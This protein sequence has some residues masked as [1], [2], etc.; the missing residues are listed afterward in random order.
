MQCTCSVK[1]TGKLAG[2]EDGAHGLR[3]ALAGHP[4]QRLGPAPGA[5][6]AAGG[7]D[8]VTLAAGASTI[9]KFSFSAADLAL[10][11]AD[12]S[13]KSYGGVHNIIFSRG[14]RNI[15]TVPVTVA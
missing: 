10:T 11:T 6:Q 7:L 4:L 13:R 3:L 8:R 2:D 5:D 12:D 15:Q 9:V 14:N 1:N